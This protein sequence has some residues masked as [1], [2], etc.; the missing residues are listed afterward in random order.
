MYSLI[1]VGGCWQTRCWGCSRLSYG[2][3]ICCGVVVVEV[4]AK[5][6]GF[7]S[8][9]A[10]AKGLCCCAPWANGLDDGGFVL[11]AQGF[12]FAA[13]ANGLPA[14]VAGLGFA[15]AV[16]AAAGLTGVKAGVDVPPD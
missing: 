1:A 5:G 8:L 11:V 2:N 7:A 3:P 9:D 6:L 15:I 4:V 14:G 12:A 13:E 16:E 10:A